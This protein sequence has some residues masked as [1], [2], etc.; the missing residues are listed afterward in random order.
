MESMNVVVDDT[1][2]RK[3]PDDT[4]ASDIQND[5]PVVTK[6]VESDTEVSSSE[7]TNAPKKGPSIRVQKNHPIEQ[8]IGNPNQ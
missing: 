5:V 3:G 7:Q 2:N 8:V 1:G 4:P 6:E